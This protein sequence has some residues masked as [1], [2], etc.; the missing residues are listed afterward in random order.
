MKLVISSDAEAD[1]TAIG[2]YIARDDPEGSA[3]FTDDL[4]DRCSHTAE[5]PRA[6]RLRPEWGKAI[7]A[8]RHGSYMIV[9]EIDGEHVVVLRVIHAKQDIAAILRGER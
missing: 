3:K 7:R 1:L 2:E 9:F 8:G 4:L 5:R 6:Y